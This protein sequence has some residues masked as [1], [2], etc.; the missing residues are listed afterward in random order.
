[1]VETTVLFDLGNTLVGYYEMRD[2]PGILRASIRQAAQYIGREEITAS[3]WQR[4]QEENF[5]AVDY[6]VRPLEDRLRRILQLSETE[7]MMGA[8]RAFMGPIF[9]CTHLYD[10]V[11]LAL[12]KLRERGVQTAIVSNTPWG[13]PP[14]LWLEEITRLGLADRVD[15]TIFCG[16]C[17]WRKPARQ[18]FDYTLDKLGATPEQ[19]LFIGDDPRWDIVGPQAVGIEALLIDRNVHSLDAL[20]RERKLI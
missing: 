18:I 3:L 9:A 13:S 10:D 14:A 12:T 19:C 16:D 6:S 4:V 20:L 15:L 17:G 7:D 5:E 1:M 11:I 2:F 8:C